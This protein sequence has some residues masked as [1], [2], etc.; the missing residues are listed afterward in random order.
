[1][2]TET[3]TTT[4]KYIYFDEDDLQELFLNKEKLENETKRI[5]EKFGFNF[6]VWGLMLNL[7]NGSVYDFLER[8]S[9]IPFIGKAWEIA[10]EEIAQDDDETDEEAKWICEPYN[11][12]CFVQ[13]IL[14]FVRNEYI[15]Q[16]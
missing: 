12:D 13:D 9:F 8:F 6:T 2:K 5:N 10:Q 11:L 1:M 3:K 4:I 14:K 16:S 15:K 7:A